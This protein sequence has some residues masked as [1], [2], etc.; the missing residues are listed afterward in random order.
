[1]I[2]LSV[3]IGALSARPQPVTFLIDTGADRT[4]LTTYDAG[5]FGVTPA[6]LRAPPPTWPRPSPTIGL[7]GVLPT[8]PFAARIELTHHNGRQVPYIGNIHVAAAG[9]T[10]PH[11]LL[12][13]D[14]LSAFELIVD[15]ARRQIVLL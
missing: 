15:P 6:Q 3:T 11:S 10:Y 8:H 12:G 13:S 2:T 7:A 1:M 9:M 14:V 4:V 5:R